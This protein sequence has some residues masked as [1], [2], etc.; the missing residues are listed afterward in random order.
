M[1]ITQ[2]ALRENL[3]IQVRHLYNQISHFA[4]PGPKLADTNSWDRLP[5]NTVFFNSG[6]SPRLPNAAYHS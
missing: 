5:P 2:A 1:I 4:C 3:K 6:P